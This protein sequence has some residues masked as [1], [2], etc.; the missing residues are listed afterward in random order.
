M[1]GADLVQLVDGIHQGSPLRTTAILGQD[2]KPTTYQK[3]PFA[4][5]FHNNPLGDF[6]ATAAPDPREWELDDRGRLRGG[7]FVQNC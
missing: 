7:P 1:L 2:G 3:Q 5:D 6:L 4:A